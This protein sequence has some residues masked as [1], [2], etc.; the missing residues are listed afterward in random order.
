MDKITDKTNITD[1]SK[2]KIPECYE[3]NVYKAIVSSVNLLTI[4][5]FIEITGFNIHPETFDKLFM[6]INDLTCYVLF[7]IMLN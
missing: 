1:L 5:E 7:L 2:I 4:R 3:K 6:N